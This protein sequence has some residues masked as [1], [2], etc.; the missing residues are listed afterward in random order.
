MNCGLAL[1]T[2]CTPA[3]RVTV[4]LQSV[5]DQYKPRRPWRDGQSFAARRGV[6]TTVGIPGTGLSYSAQ[7]KSASSPHAAG[8]SAADSSVAERAA[9]SGSP[10]PR[11]FAGLL[12]TAVIVGGLVAAR[13]PAVPPVAVATPVARSTRIAAPVVN[14]RRRPTVQS[15]VAHRLK[16]NDAVTIVTEHGGW[17]KID[18]GCWVRSSL[19][20]RD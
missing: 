6:R 19:I 7:H 20:A 14:C 8:L 9:G 3:A 18:A 13:Q 15:V 4:E 12:V 2:I 17:S 1:S 11:L 16:Q 5:R 10:L